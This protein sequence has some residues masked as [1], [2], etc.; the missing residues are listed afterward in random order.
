MR[1]LPTFTNG[2]GLLSADVLNQVMDA[3]ANVQAEEWNQF[4]QSSAWEGPRVCKIISSEAIQ[5]SGTDQN[6][7]LYEVDEVQ[8]TDHNTA[9]I[10]ANGWKSGGKYAI[11]TAEWGNTATTAAG[12]T[13]ANLPGTYALQP[14]PTDSLVILWGAATTG[15]IGGGPKWIGV[16]ERTNHFDGGC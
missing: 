1:N 16:F 5:I 8:I 10:S 6:R 15:S 11:N 3:T 4:S 7:W 2:Q 13:V 14:I 12:I 9:T